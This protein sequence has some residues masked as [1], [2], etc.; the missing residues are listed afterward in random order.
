MSASGAP[1]KTEGSVS[2]KV[3]VMAMEIIIMLRINGEKYCS[4]IGEKVRIKTETRFMWMPGMRPVK[5]PKSMPISMARNMKM[6]IK[7]QS[8]FNLSA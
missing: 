5:V 3:W 8:F 1:K 6:N 4:R 7:E 2:K